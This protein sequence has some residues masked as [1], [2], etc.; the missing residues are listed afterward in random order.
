MLIQQIYNL[1]TITK[2]TNVSTNDVIAALHT[3]PGA[4]L[5]QFLIETNKSVSVEADTT[6]NEMVASLSRS[7]LINKLIYLFGEEP[8]PENEGF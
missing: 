7:E 3:Q 5:L 6:V 4:V 1:A 2:K 8:S